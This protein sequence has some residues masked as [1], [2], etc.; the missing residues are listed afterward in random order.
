MHIHRFGDI[1]ETGYYAI[2][3]AVPGCRAGKYTTATVGPMSYIIGMDVDTGSSGLA[4][5]L[6]GNY[7]SFAH[8]IVL[9]IGQ[10]H[11]FKGVSA[12]PF[13][14]ILGEDL[15]GEVR[16]WGTVN[17]YQLVIGHDVWI[18]AHAHIIKGVKIGNGAIIGTDAVVT[19]DVPPYAI[20][21]GNP[22]KIIR[23]RF[24]PEIIEQLQQIKWWYWP[25]EKIKANCRYMDNVEDFVAR[26][27]TKSLKGEKA[28]ANKTQNSSTPPRNSGEAAGLP[29]P[30]G[31]DLLFCA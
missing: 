20:V 18:G 17:T 8:D 22:A 15:P 10:N 25:V 30:W 21:A 24:S 9:L 6:I 16:K 1:G 3:S 28:I 29:W 31:H 19:K 7:C 2:Q 23:Y 4:H 5:A 12:Y 26:F 11:A 27:G 14:T 13:G